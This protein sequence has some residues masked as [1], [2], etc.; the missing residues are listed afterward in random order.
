MLTCATCAAA[1]ARVWLLPA[2]LL[3]Q[4]VAAVVGPMEAPASQL[5][6]QRGSTRGTPRAAGGAPARPPR[7]PP[8]PPRPPPRR[9][10]PSLPA[11]PSVRRGLRT[12]RQEPEPAEA[13]ASRAWA[14]VREGAGVC[15]R[16]DAKA[17]G[18]A[19]TD[20]DSVCVYVCVCVCVCVRVWHCIIS[21]CSQWLMLHHRQPVSG[22][23]ARAV[24]AL[25]AS[26]RLLH[27]GHGHSTG[28]ASQA[29]GSSP[30]AGRPG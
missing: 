17:V 27:T 7:P 3:R 29:G 6:R 13:T 22:A 10:L 25:A 21:C 23:I 20:T 5:A 18:S 16:A 19:V 4:L 14:R 28:W 12:A 26:P 1:R 11:P 2:A 8:H 9:L 15:M 30:L 24:E